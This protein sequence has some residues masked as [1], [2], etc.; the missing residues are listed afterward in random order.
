VSNK[1]DEGYR[2]VFICMGEL[3]TEMPKNLILK[4]I[5]MVPRNSKIAFTKSGE[6]LGAINFNETAVFDYK[7]LEMINYE[8]ANEIKPI[9]P[10]AG[11][12][13]IGRDAIFIDFDDQITEISINMS[14]VASS[15][16]GGFTIYQRVRGTRFVIPTKVGG[17][18]VGGRPNR[19][20][21]QKEKSTCSEKTIIL[22]KKL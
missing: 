22:Y 3:S 12:G 13:S 19:E 18:E 5:S 10:G 11:D 17:E 9:V 21:L 16:E 15:R 7:S 8:W 2:R 4:K 1:V 14:G 20:N 6:Q